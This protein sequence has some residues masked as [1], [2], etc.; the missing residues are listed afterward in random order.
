M[1][2][3]RSRVVVAMSGGVDSS[4][5][6][7]LL[8]EQGYEVIGMMMRL[9]SE[10]GSENEN[11]CCT[12]DAIA[13]AKM[14]AAILKIPF[15]VIDAKEIFRET[16]VD[17]FISGYAQGI[18]PNPCLVCNKQIRWGY[19][20]ERTMKMGASFF[21]TGHYARLQEHKNNSI[22]LFQG[23]DK[24]KDQSYVLGTLTQQQLKS[25][26]FPV[27][28]YTKNEVRDLARKFKLPVYSVKDSQD[29]CFLAGTDYRVFIQSHSN[30]IDKQGPIKNIQ[31]EI[32][33]LHDGLALYTI[34][35]R[36]GLGIPSQE[37]MYVI[38]KDAAKNILI[39]GTSDEL[40]QDQLT[41]SKV[42][43]ISGI[44]PSKPFKAKVKI[45]YK[46]PLIP[47]KISPI[48]DNRFQVKFVKPLRDIT[49][50]QAA[51]IYQGEEVIASGIID[52]QNSFNPIQKEKELPQKKS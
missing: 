8:V 15:Y 22:R 35:Q 23:V 26:F 40:G 46:A 10:P 31:G 44:P 13:M 33:G 32:L 48:K 5:A 47:G 19:L 16:V 42:N 21:A 6:A 27:G 9:W 43:W 52:I 51:V 25:T 30:G 29:L 7:A 50:G 37:P 1:T 17:H 11:R 3:K 24:S 4:V 36:K 14:V 41:A 45:R 2:I 34:G 49:P 38:H 12:P 18:T 28:G 20:F 39:I